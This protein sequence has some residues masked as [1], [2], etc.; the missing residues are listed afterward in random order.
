MMLRQKE[1]EGFFVATDPTTG[2][3]WD[4]NPRQYLTRVQLTQMLSRPHMIVQFAHYLE[5]RLQ[6]DGYRD[7]EIR[8]RITAAL[9]GRE[10]QYLIDPAVDLSQVVYPWWGHAE[11]ILPLEKPLRR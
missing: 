6:A 7:I 1:V 8:A 9:N 5:Q 2:K 11:W 3:E 10:A 4:L